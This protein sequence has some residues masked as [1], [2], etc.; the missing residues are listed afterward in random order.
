MHFRKLFKLDLIDQ[1]NA[2]KLE[3][4]QA[5]ELYAEFEELIEIKLSELTRIEKLEVST[6]TLVNGGL[7][8]TPCFNFNNKIVW[9][10]TAL[11][12]NELRWVLKDKF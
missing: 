12:L 9:G 2:T 7:I 6:I 4:N 5:N 8:E 1:F 11:I 3:L 10:A